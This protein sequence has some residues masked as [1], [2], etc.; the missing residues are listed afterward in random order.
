MLITV[1]GV[2]IRILSQ[3]HI[4]VFDNLDRLNQ[5]KTDLLVQYLIDEGF[6][7]AGEKRIEIFRLRKKI[8]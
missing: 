3:S 4:H 8:I 5:E 6:L 2:K 1:H 7:N